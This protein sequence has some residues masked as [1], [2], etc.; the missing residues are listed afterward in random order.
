MLGLVV[1]GSRTWMC[2]IVAPALAASIAACAICSGVT[3][4]AGLRPGVSAEPV[5]A[6]EIITL[7]CMVAPEVFLPLELSL[8][9]SVARQQ[10]GGVWVPGVAQLMAWV[11]R[12]CPRSLRLPRIVR[13]STIRSYG[14]DYPHRPHIDVSTTLSLRWPS[15]A[16]VAT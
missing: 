10:G 3:G 7:R 2:T 16:F 1:F 8:L 14:A 5:T 9:D 4:P 12:C 11:R 13:C 6:Q 15:L